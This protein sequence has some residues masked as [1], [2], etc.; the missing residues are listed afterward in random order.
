MEGRGYFKQHF[1]KRLC[2]SAFSIFCGPVIFGCAFL[3]GLVALYSKL[4]GDDLKDGTARKWWLLMRVMFF[5][6]AYGAVFDDENVMKTERWMRDQMYR[7]NEDL[8]DREAQL[9]NQNTDHVAENL[10][11]TNE[12]PKTRTAASPAPRQRPWMF[13]ESA[14]LACPIC[15]ENYGAERGVVV[16][17]PCRH[18]ICH[19]C[20][21]ASTFRKKPCPCCRTKVNQVLPIYL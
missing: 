12:E 6:F 5:T 8:R 4:S 2:L 7:I 13:V 14:S 16:F 17:T 21:S 11:L 3:F 9:L 10:Q 1:F 19:Q 15:A 20:A 18:A